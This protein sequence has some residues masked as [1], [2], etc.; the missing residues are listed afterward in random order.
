LK[1]NEIE[2]SYHLVETFTLVKEYVLVILMVAGVS[3]YAVDHIVHDVHSEFWQWVCFSAM[4]LVIVAVLFFNLYP[5]YLVNREIRYRPTGDPDKSYFTTTP[6]VD[7]NYRLFTSGYEQYLNWLRNPRSPILYLTGSSGT[8]KSSLINAYL[9]PALEKENPPKT[10]V[11]VL[12]SYKDPLKILYDAL[13]ED[14]ESEENITESIVHT[15]LI[16]ISNSLKPGERILIILDQFEEFFLLRNSPQAELDEKEIK[17]IEELKNFFR[18]FIND[19]PSGVTILLSYRDDFQQLIDQLE[20]PARSEHINFEQ[21]NPL[22]FDQAAK[23]LKSCP[24]LKIPE[25]QLDRTLKEAAS[26]D[27]PVM[28]RPIVL[29]LLGITLQQM[30]GPRSAPHRSKNMIRGYIIDSLGKELKYER[31]AVL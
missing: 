25:D 19:T 4:G 22:S 5:V 6:R 24:G 29:N 9:A 30:V 17:S 21:V 20:L 1:A 27:S 15:E 18:H 16:R 3:V 7:D 26:L 2:K 8:G 10:N 14:N 13:R 28:M 31:A 11:Y 23:F 12:R